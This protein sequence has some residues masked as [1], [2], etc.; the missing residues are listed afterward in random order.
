MTA[1][2][3]RI[4]FFEM[5]GFFVSPFRARTHPTEGRRKNVPKRSYL[6]FHGNH[7]AHSVRPV[8]G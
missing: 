3:C 5:F 2:I 8:S 4:P 6:H 1:D 7:R